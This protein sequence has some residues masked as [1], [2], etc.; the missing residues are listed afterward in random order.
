MGANLNFCRTALDTDG[1]NGLLPDDVGVSCIVG[2]NNDH[3]TCTN[4]LR[5]GGGDD[6]F[7]T[8]VRG[9]LHI[10]ELSLSLQSLDFCI[11]NGGAFNRIVDVGPK[12]LDNFT[13]LE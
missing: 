8:A 11:G 6:Q 1:E 9:P 10:D 3:A 4:E 2:V 13:A 7:L 12:I 5:T